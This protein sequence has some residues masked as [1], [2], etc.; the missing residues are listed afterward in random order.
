MMTYI[1]IVCLFVGFGSSG[2]AQADEDCKTD[3]EIGNSSKPIETTDFYEVYGEP[4][5]VETNPVSLLDAIESMVSYAG[6]EMHVV[7]TVS[8]VC[9]VKGCWMVIVGDGQSARVHFRD[10]G[11]LVPTDISGRKVEL[12]GLLGE[13]MVSEEQA[14]LYA[15]DANLDDPQEGTGTHKEFTFVARSVKIYK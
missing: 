9:Q 3:V 2:T 13:K 7:A 12:V 15:A 14:K 1:L 11:F 4:W 5:H 6:E 10:F 8:E